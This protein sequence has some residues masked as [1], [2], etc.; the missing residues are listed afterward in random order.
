MSEIWQDQQIT[1]KEII[2]I[3]KANVE[4]NI[5]VMN[6]WN[7]LIVRSIVESGSQ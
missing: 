6:F 7:M 3:E 5:T 4:Q 2:I 1:I